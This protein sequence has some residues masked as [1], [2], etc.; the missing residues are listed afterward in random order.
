MGNIDMSSHQVAEV[1]GKYKN[2]S[3][4]EKAVDINEI[5]EDS[6]MIDGQSALGFQGDN[7]EER[8]K[9]DP[10]IRNGNQ[11]AV[12]TYN[13]PLTRSGLDVSKFLIST[14]DDGDP[15]LT[16]R[17]I[18]LGTIFTALSSVITMLYTF[19]PVQVQVSA[20][21]LQCI[22]SLRAGGFLL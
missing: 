6:T 14:R 13:Y 18:I 17:S 16:F 8:V 4:T 2:G 9:G 12:P 5:V 20:V 15:S 7:K 3:V 21:F 10:V 1:V 19:K 11:R 22:Y